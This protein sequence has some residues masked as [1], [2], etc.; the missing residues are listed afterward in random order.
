MRP[1]ARCFYIPVY[2]LKEEDGVPD[3]VDARHQHDGNASEHGEVAGTH[4]TP[5]NIVQ[6]HGAAFSAPSPRREQKALAVK[7]IQIYAYRYK[8]KKRKNKGNQMY[9]HL[10]QQKNVSE[11]HLSKVFLF[12]VDGAKLKGR[13]AC[14][15]FSVAFPN[16][17]LS[18][19]VHRPPCH[20]RFSL[21]TGASKIRGLSTGQVSKCTEES[22]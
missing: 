5:V 18:Y 13:Y 19:R 11:T 20:F 22:C 16:F 7:I 2:L 9:C 6:F 8:H 14:L 10:R 15:L 3:Q 1:F 4:G 12:L 17:P 21:A